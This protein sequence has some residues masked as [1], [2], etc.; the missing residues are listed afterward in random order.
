[1]NRDWRERLKQARIVYYLMTSG[2]A[3]FFVVIILGT[4]DLISSEWVLTLGRWY[5]FLLAAGTVLQ[6]IARRL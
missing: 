5:V 2:L 1:M 4:F 3:F 6:M